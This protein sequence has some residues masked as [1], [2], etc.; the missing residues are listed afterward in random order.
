M[1]NIFKKCLKNGF[2]GWLNRKP[3]LTIFFE[4]GQ[5]DNT[6]NRPTRMTSLEKGADDIQNARPTVGKA[7]SVV[8]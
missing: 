2:P 7:Q 1:K 5:T 8:L 3:W 4:E 6:A